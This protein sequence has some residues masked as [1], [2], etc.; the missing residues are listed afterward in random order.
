[1]QVE[2]SGVEPD[3]I[4]G[5]ARDITAPPSPSA[6]RSCEMRTCKRGRAGCRWVVA[7]E[8]VGET[9]TGHDAVD[10]QQQDRRAALAGPRRYGVTAR[11]PSITSSGPSIRKS[12]KRRLSRASSGVSG[13]LAARPILA[14]SG[15]CRAAITREITMH[16]IH[17]RLV[18]ALTLAIAAVPAAG[19]ALAG[20]VGE[21]ASGTPRIGSARRVCTW[22]TCFYAPT[23]CR[24]SSPIRTPRWGSRCGTA[25]SA[26]R[27]RARSYAR[28]AGAAERERTFGQQPFSLYGVLVIESRV[29]V[30]ATADGARRAFAE[31]A[32]A[33]LHRVS[34]RLPLAG[35]A[36]VYAHMDTVSG[37]SETRSRHSVPA[38]KRGLARHDRRH[39]RGS[40]PG[41]TCSSP[42]R[43]RRCGSPRRC[44]ICVMRSRLCAP[45]V[46]KIAGTEKR[47]QDHRMAPGPEETTS[48]STDAV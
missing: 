8:Q 41:H 42:R 23:T 47:G 26:T 25:P 40:S 5:R 35:G 43:G 22:R 3:Q 13:S 14:G 28:P 24:V 15:P 29:L 37:V 11:S 16:A 30:F 48:A 12:S 2:L 9:I 10:V 6:L 46:S 44:P 21:S 1:M 27:G 34:G 31:V 36:G 18:A 7:P 33:G 19:S 17:P 20:H 32:P 39:A 4:A 38:A 45:C